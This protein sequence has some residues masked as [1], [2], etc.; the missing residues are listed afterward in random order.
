[1]S[2]KKRVGLGAVLL[3]AGMVGHRGAG[4]LIT[5][6]DG[7]LWPITK[8]FED[9]QIHGQA[10]DKHMGRGASRLLHDVIDRLDKHF[11]GLESKVG[12]RDVATPMTWVRY[13]GNWRGSYRIRCALL[14]T[15]SGNTVPVCLPTGLCSKQSRHEPVVLHCGWIAAGVRQNLRPRCWVN[16]MPAT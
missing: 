10:R 4:Y 6:H 14:F 7:N 15:V 3:V 13:T 11:P 12:M 1:M 5:V 16:S 2:W 8:L 9:C